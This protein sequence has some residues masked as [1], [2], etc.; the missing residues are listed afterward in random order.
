MKISNLAEENL[1]LDEEY[2][3]LIL[4]QLTKILLGNLIEKNLFHV[5]LK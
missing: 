1:G 3:A 2:Y 4:T 5:E